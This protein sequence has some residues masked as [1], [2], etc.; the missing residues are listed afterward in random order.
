[1]PN[2]KNVNILSNLNQPKYK[3]AGLFI[4]LMTLIG[5]LA[6]QNS[7]GI[8]DANAASVS[9]AS[10]YIVINELNTTGD[11]STAIITYSK[12]GADNIKGFACGVNTTTA[13]P[14]ACILIIK[15]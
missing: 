5:V 14:T 10:Q 13:Q 11:I 6:S 3:L 1:M 2:T 9:S 7:T 8:F 15:K 4:A 12:G